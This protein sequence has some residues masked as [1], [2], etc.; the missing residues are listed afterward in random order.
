[1]ATAAS[2]TAASASAGTAAPVVN[3]APSGSRGNYVSFYPTR[4]Q[5]IAEFRLLYPN[6]AIADIVFYKITKEEM[7]SI[8]EKPI[9]VETALL[10]DRSPLRPGDALLEDMTFLIAVTRT[11]SSATGKCQHSI[12][13][14]S[15][16][17]S[18]FVTH[19]VVVAVQGLKRSL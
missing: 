4:G 6:G 16:A 17:P 13:F 15:V 9:D 18:S 2:E 12:V 3:V 14:P 11:P 19:A 10:K 5:T 1:M 7:D 8:W